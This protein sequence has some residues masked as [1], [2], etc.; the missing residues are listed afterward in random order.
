MKTSAFRQTV[1]GRVICSW[2]LVSFIGSAVIPSRVFAQAAFR[3]PDPGTMVAMSDAYVPVIL[4]GLTVHAN[5]PFLFDFIVDTGYS[6]LDVK[7]DALRAETEKL[8]KYFLAS[9]AIPAKDQ[10]VNLSPYEKDRM[11]AADLER[12]DLGRDM[13]AQDYLLKQVTASLIYPEKELGKAFWDK[14]YTQV[15]A[16]FGDMDI[17]M[18]MFN[19]VW[20]VADKANVFVNRGAS[21]GAEQM[22]AVIVGSHLK[23]MLDSDYLAMQKAQGN[24]PLA[25][26]DGS[27]ELV[28]QAVRE[29]VLPALEKEVNEGKNFAKLRQLFHSMVL[30]TW[31]KKA[32]K[33]AFL[34]QVYANKMKTGGVE[35]AW[36][37]GKGSDVDPQAI[38]AKYVEAYKRGVFN[39]IKE[40]IDQVSGQAVPRKYFSG[41]LTDMAEAHEVG[42]QDFSQ[43]DALPAG[44]LA[45]FTVQNELN[46]DKAEEVRDDATAVAELNMERPEGYPERSISNPPTYTAA[47]VLEKV[48]S[49]SNPTGWAHP[50]INTLVPAE[51]ARFLAQLRDEIRRF[52]PWT[53]FVNNMPRN[54]VETGMLGRGL[55]GRFGPNPAEDAI[56]LRYNKE[57]RLEVLVEDRLDGGGT[58]LPGVLLAPGEEDQ[59]GVAAT[60]RLFEETNVTLDLTKGVLVYE[61][62]SSDWRDTNDAWVITRGIATLLS[63][64]ESLFLKPQAKKGAKVDSVRFVPVDA[65]DG[66]YARHKMIIERAVE[67]VQAGQIKTAEDL[68]VKKFAPLNITMPQIEKAFQ[69]FKEGKTELAKTFDVVVPKAPHGGNYIVAAGLEATLNDIRRLRFLP[70]H[71]QVLRDTRYFSEDFLEYLRTFQFQGDIDIVQDGRIVSEGIPLMRLKANEV[72]MELMSALLKNRLGQAANI[73]TKTSRIVQAARG[74]FVSDE[75]IT[76]L[77]QKYGLSREQIK[78]TRD[79]LDFGL[80]RGQGE[81]AFLASLA[82]VIG[83]AIGTSNE[84]AANL[85][86]LLSMGSIAH[87]FIMMFDA[88]DEI[89]AF[90]LYARLFPKNAILLVDTYDTLEGVR[91]A[92]TVAKEMEARGEKLFGIRLDSGD[93]A[94]L[95]IKAR[96]MLN[97]AGLHYVKI[98]ASDDLDEHKI[99][100]LLEA[101]AQ[102]DVF[103]VGTNLITGGEQATLNVD[104]IP[105]EGNRIWRS[106]VNGQVEKYIVTSK[107]RIAVA[108]KKQQVNELLVPVW[109]GGK[110]VLGIEQPWSAHERAV[111]ETGRLTLKQRSLTGGTA[112]SVV[113][114]ENS[115]LINKATDIS[116]TVDAQGAF[117]PGGGLPV[118]GGEE[119]AAPLRVSLELFDAEDRYISLD[120]HER[121]SV[122]WN[123][124]YNGLPPYT[125]LTYDMVK[126]WKDGENRLA[127]HAKFT[128]AQLKEYLQAVGFQVLWPEHADARSSESKLPGYLNEKMFKFIQV[129]GMDPTVDS[130]SPFEDNL[131][132]ATSLAEIIR[133]N[134]PGTKRIFINGGLAFD[135]CVGFAALGAVKAGFEV[136]LVR[137]ATRSVGMPEGNVEAMEKMLLE[138]GVKIVDSTDLLVA[139]NNTQGVYPAPVLAESFSHPPLLNVEESAALDEDKYHL[140]MSYA[141]FEGGYKDKIATFDYFF[142]QAPYGGDKIVLSGLRILAERLRNF[143]FTPGQIQHLR[144]QNIYSEEFLQ[145]LSEFKFTGD[146]ITLPEGSAGFA[147]EPLFK[148]SGPLIET[149]IIEALVLNKLNFNSLISTLANN[150]RHSAGEVRLVEDGLTGAQGE[151]HVEASLA[152]FYGGVEA[153]TNPDAHWNYGIPL[154]WSNDEGRTLGAE[155]V[156]GGI[157]SSL[158]GVYKMAVI[159]GK[160]RIKL[161]ATAVKT[162]R[163]GDKE[164]LDIVDAQG[165][166]VDRLTALVGEKLELAEGQKAV[167]RYVP[168]AV[169]GDIVFAP[170][171]P[172]EVQ[173]FRAE[174]MDRYA[175]IHASRMS[176]GLEALQAEMIK[177]IRGDTGDK[178][179][180][181]GGIDFNSANMDMTETGVK[182]DMTFDKAMMEQF[183]H[184]DFTGIRPVIIRVTPLPDVLPLL[185][186]NPQ[187]VEGTSG[188]PQKV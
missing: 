102:I 97:E 60:R 43:R 141:F 54:P 41:G 18:D 45:V 124:S 82:A 126:D 91:K 63:Y 101:G 182:A 137:D 11:M 67:K 1:T 177:D 132:R 90:R 85:Y 135:Y 50:D 176:P 171:D 167:S 80:R 98:V 96:K 32:L 179:S 65:L 187:G 13:L 128:L 55:L 147:N 95:S 48:R 7:S 138:K 143:K 22:T 122:S 36:V 100:Q 81:G 169:A 25:K 120:R 16:K 52:A 66:F 33:E 61:G 104:I 186:M 15:K 31:Y 77:Q 35:G 157:K 106:T 83:G 56:V 119:I 129:K 17:P 154:A 159:D 57:G 103:G 94:D 140:T 136:I 118:A 51:K 174:Q 146:I 173:A 4:K 160:A 29:L 144:E 142:R 24:N 145:Y 108:T 34:T 79:V 168:F 130:Y 74:D 99:T 6:K 44:Q 155:F 88:E 58:A 89:E 185:G 86:N 161:G 153:S 111:N 170:K 71:I 5:D 117:V 166:V 164:A 127:P 64:E 19:K 47:P 21:K 163:P 3:L 38:Y 42:P 116:L 158:G 125:L 109:R 110:R 27:Q 76:E 59:F 165:M 10:W 150:E 37:T 14:L 133:L 62:P 75:K 92:I 188:G 70:E 87:A 156:T 178:A 114:Q 20:V 184:G 139:A 73:A 131:R 148:V 40:N 46:A 78:R 113:S 107:D 175:G 53:K 69:A 162:T 30:A 183:R 26:D 181:N 68:R 12:T 23:V 39:Y 115:L 49:R 172:F 9:M 112:L 134:K 2:I 121:G 149:L 123:T 93:I 151:S 180:V 105:S 84:R 152:A 28:K 8:I 72:D